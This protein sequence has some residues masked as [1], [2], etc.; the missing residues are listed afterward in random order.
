[1]EDRLS[2]DVSEALAAAARVDQ[3]FAQIGT[4]LQTAIDNALQSVSAVQVTA[5]VTA[6]T[7]DV[8]PAVDSAIEAANSVVPVE[9]DAATITESIDAALAAADTVVPVDADTSEAQAAIDALSGTTVDVDVQAQGLEELAPQLD[10]VASSGHAAAEGAHEAGGAFEGLGILGGVAAGETGALKEGLTAIGPAGAIAAG[11]IGAVA[12]IGHELVTNAIDAR[13]AQ[14]RY[15]LVLGEFG[16]VVEHIDIGGLNEDLSTLSTR[17]GSTGVEV[18]NAA[19]KIFQIGKSSG[20]AGPQIAETTK[21]VLALAARAVAL[22]PALGNVGST[23]ERL[24]NGLSRGGR[25]AANFGLALTSADINARALADTG[26]AVAADLTIYEKSAAGAAIAT[27]RLGSSLSTDI[28]AGAQNV[29]IQF[30]AIKAKFEEALET[31]GQPLLDPLLAAI[32]KAEPSIEKLAESFAKVLPPVIEIGAALA[33]SLAPA[34]EGVVPVA[35]AIGSALGVVADVLNAIPGPVRTA[36][37]SFVILNV[38]LK[39]LAASS[40][41]SAASGF[42]GLSGVMAGLPAAVLPAAAALAATAGTLAFLKSQA[43]ETDEAVSGFL[44]DVVSKA[45]NAGDIEQLV[46]LLDQVHTKAQAERDAAA[47]N[48]GG[49]LGDLTTRGE[50]RGFDEAAAG[51]ESIDTNGRRLV[52]TARNLQRE[53]GL[54]SAAALSLARG[55]EAAIEAFKKQDDVIVQLTADQAAAARSTSEFWLAA[56]TGAL[57]AVE[58]AD[59]AAASGA[60]FEDLA[61]SVEKARKPIVDFA[62]SVS[63]A[64]PGVSSAFNDLGANE[65]LHKFLENAQKDVA[66]AAAFISNLDTLIARGATNLASTFESLATT[67]PTKAARLAAEAVKEST[68]DLGVD[69]GKA[70]GLNFQEGFVALATQGV[71]DKLHG[72]LELEFAKTQAEIGTR[73]LNLPGQVEAEGTISGKGI[74]GNVIV[75]VRET[76]DAFSGTAHDKGVEIGEQLAAGVG[77]GLTSGGGKIETE[78]QKFADRV[79]TILRRV[80]V[81]QSPSQLTQE[82]GQLVAAGF[83]MGLADTTGAEAAVKPILDVVKKF[84]LSAADVTKAAGSNVDELTKS[85]TDLGKANAALTPDQLLKV[86]DAVKALSGSSGVKDLQANIA[87]QVSKAFGGMGADE[88]GKVVSALTTKSALDRVTAFSGVTPSVPTPFATNVVKGEDSTARSIT[89]QQD[90]TVTPPPDATTAEI[91]GDIA[92]ASSWALQGVTV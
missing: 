36:V 11:A 18:E 39:S 34:I 9:A 43:K 80:F 17:L 81:I 41:I 32:T 2:L 16:E 25:F 49:F 74:I 14:E 54:S 33:D 60:T 21:E 87:Q 63:D 48:R 92:V 77:A 40:L 35:E 7:E 3:A 67:D 83:Y 50:T 58:I 45:Q 19:A 6:N 51:L 20:E 26:K 59:Q 72:G 91:A 79:D 13:S 12:I 44:D 52:E 86:G 38:V 64:L 46:G 10:A 37:A 53:F 15:N 22:N 69:E 42:S 5:D 66:A 4:T 57:S 68:K 8:T 65:G 61:T 23:A 84:S 31:F 55:G 73:L 56:Q 24:F 78:A 27:E 76:L 71:T 88:I 28:N 75:A 29:A 70:A 1:M 89:V 30:A 62:T 90:I 82:I 85:L 47:K